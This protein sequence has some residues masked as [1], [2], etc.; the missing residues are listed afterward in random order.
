MLPGGQG[1]N[2]RAAAFGVLPDLLRGAVGAA[3]RLAVPLGDA[4]PPARPSTV[5]GALVAVVLVAVSLVLQSRVPIA[6]RVLR[7]ARPRAGRARQL[8]ASSR[9]TATRSRG[10]TAWRILYTTTR[11]E[12]EPAVASG[13]VIARRADVEP[14]RR[15]GARDH[16][17]RAGLRAVRTGRRARR[18]RD[19]LQDSGA[20][21]R[22]GHGRDRLHRARHR[23]ARTRT[24][25]GRARAVRPRRRP[26]LTSSPT[27]P[28]DQTVLWGHSQGGH[29][30]LWA[31]D[32]G[33]GLRARAADRRRRCA[34]AREQPPGPRR[35]VGVT[36]GDLVRPRRRSPPVASTLGP[37]RSG[38]NTHGYPSPGHAARASVDDGVGILPTN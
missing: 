31:R 15:V 24:S 25:S 20:R 38:R 4:G 19:V 12:G 17:R 32:A 21:R 8:C 29:A 37:R 13:L 34:R 3:G 9:S 6:R 22:L 7:P 36:G 27:P 1:G 30:A 14:R 18:R 35:H 28:G 2:A 23:P 5:L 26:A 16:R 33:A 11:D 10:A